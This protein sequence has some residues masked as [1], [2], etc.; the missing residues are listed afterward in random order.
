MATLPRC[1]KIKSNYLLP[2]I[3][4]A[5]QTEVFESLVYCEFQTIL[6]SS[7]QPQSPLRPARRPDPHFDILP[8][9]AQR[10]EQAVG[11]EQGD[12]AIDQARN[13]GHG[14]SRLGNMPL[15]YTPM[16]YI[17]SK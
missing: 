2:Y 7:S 1:T 11:R 15:T 12:L 6:I 9:I 5:S 8:Q 10:E 14:L 3:H 16:A 17:Q 4:E 13:K